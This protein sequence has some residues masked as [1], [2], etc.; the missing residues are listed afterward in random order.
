MTKKE[1][2]TLA[3]NNRNNI[4]EQM[5]A[6]KSRIIVQKIEENSDFKNAKLIGVYYPFGSEVDISNLDHSNAKFAYPKIINGKMEFILV[7][8]KTKWEKSSFGVLEPVKGKI[9]NEKIDLLIVSS[10]AKNDNKYRLG[11]G[12]GYYD[13]F[14]RLYPKKTIGILFDNNKIDFNEDLWD[15]PLDY[16][17]SN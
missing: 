7:N 1:A 14:L 12:K 13:N 8:K 9:V 6:I 15:I 2:R 10:L 11:Y 17:I 4:D 16:Y 3:L 5:R